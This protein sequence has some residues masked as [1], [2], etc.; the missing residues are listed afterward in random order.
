M[1]YAHETTNLVNDCGERMCKEFFTPSK[2]F[3]R[4]DAHVRCIGQND[5]HMENVGCDQRDV[6]QQLMESFGD[7]INLF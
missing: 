7:K 1:W 4:Q 5:T 2:S 6:I 3:E